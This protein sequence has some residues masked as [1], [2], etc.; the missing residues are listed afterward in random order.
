MHASMVALESASRPGSVHVEPPHPLPRPRN[1]SHDGDAALALR[2]ATGDTTALDTLYQRHYQPALAVAIALL[3]DRGAAEDLVHEAF[4]R[5]WQRASSFRSHRGTF[6]SWLLTIVRNAAVDQLRQ[7]AMQ[8]KPNILAAQESLH[9]S[10]D[11]DIPAQ[12][13]LSLEAECLHQALAR[14][15]PEQRLAIQHAFF[16]ELTHREI[17]DHEGLPLGTVKGRVR[18]GLQ[19]MRMLLENPESLAGTSDPI[20]T[21]ARSSQ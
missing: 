16:G 13:I 12:V 2:L 7:Q 4:L 21:V 19:R 3:R 5:A 17:A 15:T 18:L 11:L 20:L 14:L 9:V 10:A 8:R 1:A 6:R